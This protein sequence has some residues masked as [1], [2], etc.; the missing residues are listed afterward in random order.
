MA[1]KPKHRLPLPAEWQDFPS[2]KYRFLQLQAPPLSKASK[3]SLPMS[4]NLTEE[5]YFIYMF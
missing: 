2:C 3:A 1:G 5:Y 4:E